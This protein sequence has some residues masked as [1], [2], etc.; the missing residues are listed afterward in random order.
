MK[1]NGKEEEKKGTKIG[2]SARLRVGNDR[3]CKGEVMND[4]NRGN[5]IAV[6]G[7]IQAEGILRGR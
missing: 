5:V 4:V 1:I 2:W 7:E 3:D 6:E